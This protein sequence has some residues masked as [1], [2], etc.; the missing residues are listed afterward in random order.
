MTQEKLSRMVTGIVVAATLFLAVL[1]GVLVYQWITMGVQQRRMD[2][3]LAEWVEISEEME[4][5]KEDLDEIMY[6]DT[7]K[8]DLF[9]KYQGK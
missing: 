9:L 3:A 5:R 8:Y 7:W 4:E 1:F 6:D 2:A